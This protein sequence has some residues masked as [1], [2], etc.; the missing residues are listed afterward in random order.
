MNNENYIPIFDSL[1][2]IYSTHLL[3]QGVR[4]ESLRQAFK[5]LYSLDPEFIARSPGRVN[6]IGEHIDYSNFGVLPMAI[7]RDLL[8]AVATTTTDSR[9]RIANM[10][11]RFPAREF[12]F[13][14]KESIVSIDAT[15]LEWSNYFKCG[16]KA[17]LEKLKL[18][19]PR[20]MYM[21]VHGT[22]PTGAGV[23]SSAAFVCAA[24]VATLRANNGTLTKKELTELA[25]VGERNVGVNSGG[26]DQSASVFA[27][28]GHAVHIE[29]WPTLLP[30]PVALSDPKLVFVVANTLVQADKHVTAPTNYNLRVVETKIGALALSKALGIA[31][32]ETYREVLDTY[33]AGRSELSMQERL[34]MMLDLVERH[35]VKQEGYTQQELAQL[36]GMDE[37]LMVSKYMTRFPVRCDKFQLY[38][39]AKHVF[40]EALR[41]LQFRDVCLDSAD[42]FYELGALMNASQESCRDLYNCSCNEIDE[43]TQICR[44]AGASGSRLTGAGWG[45]CTVSLVRE[46]R[47][48]DFIR[49]VK[50][51]YYS[52]KFPFMTDS[53]LEDVIFATKPGSGAAIFVINQ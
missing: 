1:D 44:N 14:G 48:E 38:K 37:A 20:G 8:I 6:L 34:A 26:M 9:V 4:Y 31:D 27:E 51:Q 47:V 35:F 40:S 17:I 30:K 15:V 16:Y 13:E 5:D 39:R 52:K 32:K 28:R 22:V 49:E 3:Q 53:E 45:G 23:S 2:G 7:E 29:F 21:L 43:L 11:T 12:D 19:K 24:A 18:D 10:D 42:P 25:I 36:I 46:E 41:V 50:Q 33:F